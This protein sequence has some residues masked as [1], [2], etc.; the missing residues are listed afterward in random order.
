[1]HPQEALEVIQ[2]L[3]DQ[4][5]LNFMLEMVFCRSSSTKNLTKMALF[6]I[7]F[8]A[9]AIIIEFGHSSG[10]QS[11]NV[12][13]TYSSPLTV[14]IFVENGQFEIKFPNN[15]VSIAEDFKSRCIDVL[16]K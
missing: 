10:I 14:E 6:T 1:M 3:R 4:S 7:S 13:V 16:S 2:I 8:N 11:Y 5:T 12:S 9:N 15:E